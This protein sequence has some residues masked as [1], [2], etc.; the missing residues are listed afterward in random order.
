[1]K[2]RLLLFE[3]CNR[4]CKG[5]CNKDWDLKALSKINSF[6][7]FDEIL[8]TG[9]EPMLYPQ[10]VIDTI[11]RIRKENSTTKIYMY[12]AHSR[13]LI[14]NLN[15]LYNLDGIVITLHNQ[16]D[17]EP[18]IFFV[19]ILQILGL[20]YKKPSRKSLRVNIFKGININISKLTMWKV[21]NNMTWIKKC[22][23]P[24]NEVFMKL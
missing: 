16:Q 15:I 9:G 19:N 2:L 14:K 21:K 23:L 3:E 22:P 11:K 6:R 12:T 18:F 5:C 20:F 24:E 10:L 8:L 1:M 17:V 7:G 13:N 4:K